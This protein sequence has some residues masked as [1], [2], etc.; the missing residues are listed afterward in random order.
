MKT[1][2]KTLT[3]TAILAAVMLLFGFT[4]IG[5][6]PI[7]PVQVT[8]MC[9]PLI[10][11]T[12]VLGLRT[13]FILGIVFAVT[14]LVQLLMGTSVLFNLLIPNL[15]FGWDMAAILLIIFV[16]RL[17]IAPLTTLTYKGIGPGRE[18]LRIGIASVVGSLTNTVI[19]LG[20]LYAFFGGQ[21]G[22]LLLGGQISASIAAFNAGAWAFILSIGLLNGLPEAAAALLVCVPVVSALKKTY[23]LENTGE[24]S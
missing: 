5:Y 3:L 1:K 14:S 20:M 15:K 16:P 24:E 9:L 7:G 17:L 12:I 8:L 22:S 10:I 18:K 2:T 19:F 6:I 21:I 4:P 11:G 23:R 13:G